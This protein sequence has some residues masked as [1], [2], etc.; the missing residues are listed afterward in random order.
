[1]KVGVE[2]TLERILGNSLSGHT[3]IVPGL[4]DQID[5]I[6]DDSLGNLSSW[7]VE[8]ECKVVLTTHCQSLGKTKFQLV[9]KD[10]LWRGTSV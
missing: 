10:P 9:I 5:S 8:K 6:L 2:E 4:D 7:L 1:M 3:I